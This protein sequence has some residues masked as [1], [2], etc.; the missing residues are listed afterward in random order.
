MTTQNKNLKI[1][2][3]AN[4]AREMMN[5][6]NKQWIQYNMREMKRGIFKREE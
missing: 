3:R 5:C 2:A 6:L 1:W 4:W